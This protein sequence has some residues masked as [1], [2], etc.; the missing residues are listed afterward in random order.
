MPKHP[1]SSKGVLQ[2]LRVKSFIHLASTHHNNY[3][4]CSVIIYFPLHLLIWLK[5]TKII[6][7]FIPIILVYGNKN[8]CLGFAGWFLYTLLLLKILLVWKGVMWVFGGT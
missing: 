4:I 8:V 1:V 3:G 2:R 6:K 7:I 5:A